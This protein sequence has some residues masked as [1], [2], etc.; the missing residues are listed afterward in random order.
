MKKV[1]VAG[2]RG[3]VGS[4][5]VEVLTALGG[6]KIITRTHSELDLSDRA[7]TREFF[8]GPPA[9]SRCHVRGQGRWH[10][11]E[12]EPPSRLPSH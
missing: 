2:H 9:G 5:T 8:H 1:F 11:G 12:F 6:Y 7:A 10:S 4:A 3:L